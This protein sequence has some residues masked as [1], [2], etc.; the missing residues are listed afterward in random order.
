A[1]PSRGP[2]CRSSAYVTRPSSARLSTRVRIR[3]C[4]SPSSTTYAG[5]TAGSR[6]SSGSS[7]PRSSHHPAATAG[8]TPATITKTTA[9]GC[10]QPKL[11]AASRSR[12][13]AAA[14]TAATTNPPPISTVAYPGQPVTGVS[15]VGPDTGVQLSTRPSA[16]AVP[17]TIQPAAIGP[18]ESARNSAAH[19]ANT[20]PTP[21]Q[22]G[23]VPGPPGFS[24][25][26]DHGA[27]SA[28][29]SP[30]PGTPASTSRSPGD[31]STSNVHGAST[32][33]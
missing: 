21:S 33:G 31:R 32:T 8:V 19:A 4:R 30:G 24:S 15:R 18:R 10:R 27:S 29:D 12:R 3:S 28:S 11:A 2:D 7:A 16:S 6:R 9:S 20:N 23:A 17:A 26:T 5:S 1:S 25:N 22:I 14:A 13:P